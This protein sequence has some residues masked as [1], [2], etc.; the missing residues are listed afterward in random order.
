MKKSSKVSLT[1]VAA[2]GIA[3]AQ[4]PADPCE[5]STFNERACQEAIRQHGYCWNG[6]WVRLR[7]SYPYPYYYDRYQVYALLVGPAAPAIVDSCRQ[8]YGGTTTSVHSF[9]AARG[10]FG[11]TG[12]HSAGA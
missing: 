6:S 8:P 12:C 3:H 1:V 5:A 7:Y 9:R 4:E 10:G 2:I 11:T